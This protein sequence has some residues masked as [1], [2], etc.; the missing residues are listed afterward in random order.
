MTILDMLN[1]R[2]LAQ[3]T[4]LYTLTI[5][6][7][8]ETS[9]LEGLSEDDAAREIAT[10]TDPNGAIVILSLGDWSNVPFGEIVELATIYEGGQSATLFVSRC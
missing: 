9:T 7:D 1:L 6:F 8:G 5:D 4:P 3:P 10:F 2:I